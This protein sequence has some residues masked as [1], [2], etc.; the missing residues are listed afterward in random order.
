MDKQKIDFPALPETE[1]NEVVITMTNNSQKEHMVEIVPPNPKI[2][3]LM[4]NPLVMSLT[5][6]KSTLLSVKYT[7]KFRDLT[8][9]FMKDMF[10]PV[11]ELH[12]GIAPGTVKRNRKLE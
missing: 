7:S 6:G 9:K 12:G 3:G 5:P 11:N 2:S 4:V 10:N 8:H 1:F